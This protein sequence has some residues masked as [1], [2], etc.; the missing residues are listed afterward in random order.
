MNVA[1]Q[2]NNLLDD[3]DFCSIVFDKM[4]ESPR[5]LDCFEEL[6]AF[7]EELGFPASDQ[8]VQALHAQF[9]SQGGQQFDALGFKRV[10][11]EK[12]QVREQTLLPELIDAFVVLGGNSDTSG[13]VRAREVVRVLA[14][15]IGSAF[16]PEALLAS[17]GKEADDVLS[18]GEFQ[19]FVNR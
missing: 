13:G 11:T 14:E 7:V 6:R 12:R 8:E 3:E 1:V 18:F 5:P 10:V 15:M 17:M 9:N 19:K 2:A 16:K 4:Q